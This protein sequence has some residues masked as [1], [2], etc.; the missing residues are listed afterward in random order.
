M[1][2]P[3]EH[4]S[5]KSIGH[6]CLP[7]LPA[8]E[9]WQAEPK[10]Q[11]SHEDLKAFAESLTAESFN[12]NVKCCGCEV[13]CA[14]A[15]GL[16]NHLK[17]HGAAIEDVKHILG[18]RNQTE[19]ARKERGQKKEMTELERSSLCPYD[20]YTKVKCK[21]G[22]LVPKAKISW[23]LTESKGHKSN[24]LDKGAILQWHS[25]K[26]GW[27]ISHK[28]AKECCT[29]FEELYKAGEQAQPASSQPSQQHLNQM[30]ENELKEKKKE[31]KGVK[32]EPTSACQPPPHPTASQ[33]AIPASGRNP[34]GIPAARVLCARCS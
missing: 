11:M 27:Q 18:L 16:V 26:D 7:N 8:C 12:T 23:H 9:T 22:Q 2:P 3:G 5:G 13:A 15:L 19:N 34:A 28:K 24:P 21:C 20:D 6:R 31:L 1:C 32:E 14:T 30:T 4:I 29:S 33:P 17:K 10:T 25:V